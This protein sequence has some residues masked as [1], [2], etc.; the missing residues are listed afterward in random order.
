MQEDL[1]EQINSTVDTINSIAQKIALLNDQ[2]NDVEINGSYAND[3]RDQ[4]AL[5]VDQLSS[6]EAVEVQETKVVNSNYPDMDT[7]A[8]HYTV[9]INGLSL[10]DDN[11]YRQL[12][13]VA[14]EYKDN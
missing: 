14:R 7:G 1:N 4:R 11:Q 10:V 8:T 3:M 5:L 2:I 6:S 13:C 9:K 12:E